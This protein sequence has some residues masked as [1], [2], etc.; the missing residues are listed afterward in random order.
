MIRGIAVSLLR[1]VIG[2]NFE[3]EWRT[4]TKSR[5]IQPGMIVQI[6]H[7]KFNSIYWKFD[8][9]DHHQALVSLGNPITNGMFIQYF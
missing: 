6:F 9:H 7:F 1:P 3:I 2:S 5:R 4:Q 8:F